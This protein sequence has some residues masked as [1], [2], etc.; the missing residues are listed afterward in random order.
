MNGSR[1]TARLLV[2]SI[3]LRLRADVPVGTSL[4]GGID[5]SAIVALSALLAGANRR[6]AF[7]ASF[8]GF[9]RDETCL[10]EEAARAAGVLEHHLIHPHAD[11]LLADLDRLVADQQEPFMTTSIYAQWRV[12]AAA[13]DAGVTVLL[14]GQGAD[15]LF[16]GYDLSGGW[17][18]RSSGVRAAAGG[19]VRG[20]AR[21]E[22]AKTMA[23][24]TVPRVLVRQYR[25]SLASPYAS[26][27]AVEDA[28]SIEP[29]PVAGRSPM[30]RNLLR[31]AFHISLPGL[32]RFADRNSMAH[33]RE[34]R[35]PYLDR[36]IAELALSLPPD[37]LFRSGT[38]KRVLRDAVRGIVPDSFLVGATRDGSRR[39]RSS[40]LRLRS[41]STGQKKCCSTRSCRI[42]GSTTSRRSK[43]MP[44]PVA[45]GMRRRFGAR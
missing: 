16:G 38:T 35:L 23:V 30:Q 4:S 13:R 39:Q 42:P 12:M 33:S 19:L 27:A 32:L 2:D 37:Y 25:R 10:A 18:L 21:L 31:E 34:L 36:R 28:V 1:P 41:S 9:A 14:D 7:T 26:A 17:A 29:P 44:T 40:G 45:G 8:P 3:R 11:Q 22:K 6:H 20:P 24:G 5:S 15:E 43:P